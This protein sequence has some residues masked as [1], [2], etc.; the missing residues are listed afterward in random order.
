[1]L[2]CSYC[3]LSRGHDFMV[4]FH[5][6]SDITLVTCPP[7]FSAISYFANNK[8][9]IRWCFEK[10][11]RSDSYSNLSLFLYL[12]CHHR[13]NGYIFFQ[14]NIISYYC[15]LFSCLNCPDLASGKPF[16]LVSGQA[17]VSL[18]ILCTFLIPTLDAAISS[19]SSHILWL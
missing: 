5:Y 11:Y 16:N 7:G 1:M 13:Y 8:Y 18:C 6:Y 9:F 17:L 2:G 15:Y 14:W 3:T 10:M 19:L 4:P 12:L